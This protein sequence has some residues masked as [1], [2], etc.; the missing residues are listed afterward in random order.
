MVITTV[1]PKWTRSMEIRAWMKGTD[2]A[3]LLVNAPAKDK[4]V[5]FL[6]RKKEVWKTGCPPWSAPSNCRP[7]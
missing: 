5:A 4:G 6:K 2:Y 3:L 7:P 1:R